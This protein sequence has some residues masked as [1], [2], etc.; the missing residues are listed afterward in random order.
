MSKEINN[1]IAEYFRYC[2]EN[3]CKFIKFSYEIEERYPS[4]FEFMMERGVL[5]LRLEL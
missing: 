4:L 1:F 5:E 3:N 2:K